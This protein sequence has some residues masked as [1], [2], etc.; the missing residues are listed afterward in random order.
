MFSHILL[1]Q[2]QSDD[3]THMR[4]PIDFLKKVISF[5]TRKILKKKTGTLKVITVNVLRNEHC[6]FTYTERNN[7]SN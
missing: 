3:V 7:Y 4:D 6:G 1:V 5:L 2:F